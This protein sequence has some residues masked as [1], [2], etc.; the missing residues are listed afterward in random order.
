MYSAEGE[1]VPFKETVYPT[2][3]V[4]DWL[5]EVERVMR[6]SLRKTIGEAIVNYMEVSKIM[7]FT[8]CLP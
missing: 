2:G 8:A 1:A 5:L 3:N 6:E 4:E 7:M